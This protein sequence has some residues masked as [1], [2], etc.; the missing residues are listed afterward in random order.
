MTF[1][2]DHPATSVLESLPGAGPSVAGAGPANTPT[3]LAAELSA[4]LQIPFRATTTGVAFD[5]LLSLAD[6]SIP[7][8]VEGHLESRQGS[9]VPVDFVGHALW[10]GLRPALDPS[11]G[12][13]QWTCELSIFATLAIL[14]DQFAYDY[15]EDEIAAI[16]R[17]DR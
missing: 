7:L 9:L 17:P 4:V 11:S 2:L 15:D 5:G 13:T 1:T 16:T 3:F 6:W 8:I 10:A 12:R 14:D